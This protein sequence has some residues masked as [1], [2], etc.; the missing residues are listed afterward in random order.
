MHIRRQIREAIKTLVDGLEVNDQA[1]TAYTNRIQELDVCDLPVVEIMTA[2]ENSE[3]SSK[4]DDLE[5]RIDVT[6][7]VITN[8]ASDTLDD[9]LDDWA[10]AIEPLQKTVPPARDMELTSTSLD[11]Q[12]DDEGDYWFGYLAMSYQAH[13]FSD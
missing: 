2:E 10:E 6:V 5:R 12:P 4:D 1:L 9:D 7:V 13:A 11:L 3:T 8:G